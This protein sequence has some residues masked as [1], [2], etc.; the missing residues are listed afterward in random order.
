MINKI[1]ALLLICTSIVLLF[2][3]IVGKKGVLHL[4][5]VNQE[6]EVLEDKD[7]K[8]QKEINKVKNKIYAIKH[9]DDVLE[10]TSREHL[11]LSK[12]G[13]IVYII[14]KESPEKVTNKNRVGYETSPN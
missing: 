5:H 7:R 10:Q 12:P 1:T 8:L 14:R 3:T 4:Q 11:G 2:F 9:S 6:L 13:E